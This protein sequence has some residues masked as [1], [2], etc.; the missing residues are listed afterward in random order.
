MKRLPSLLPVAALA[1]GC[2]RQGRQSAREHA[3][4]ARSPAADASARNGDWIT[5]LVNLCIRCACFALVVVA[6]SLAGTLSLSAQE[7][8][9]PVP[10]NPTSILINNVRVFDGVSDELRQGNLLIVGNKIKQ[11]TSAPITPP[12]HSDVIDGGGR[13]LMPG[14]TDAHWHMTIAAN[15][16]ANL[17][18]ADPGLMYANTV[19]EAHRTLLRGF[20]TVRDM[21]GPTFGI[22]AAI[23]A[24]VIPGPRVYPSGALISQTTGH[25][26]F[27]PPYERPKALGGRS[28]HLED[29]GE[30]VVADGVR[31]VLAAV[32]EQLKKGASQIKLAAG[33]GVIS[34]FD[35]IDSTQFTPEE[36]RAAVQA[37]SDWGTYVAVHVY[38]PKAI[39]RALD[40]GV[41]SIEHGHLADEATVRLITEKGAWL[42]MQPF[43]P[44]DE[45]L[46]PENAA[47]TKSM[48]GA[49]ER[50]LGWAK[51]YRAKVAFG[52]DLLFDPTGAYKENIMLTR[53]AKI[54][55]N[56]DVLKIA[57]SGNC[58]L[59][60]QSG[61]RN[62][63]KQPKLGVL[64]EGAWADML[65][66]DG[67]P[68]K[69]I[70]VLADPQRNFVV[71]IKDGKVYKNALR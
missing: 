14:L 71:I 64:E 34:N 33:G 20:T 44:G 17:E 4:A 35:L 22:K 41:L 63:Y 26:D 16:L 65:L 10:N 45:P 69:E 23:D 47:K 27:A 39:R 25:G 9:P 50:V 59:F 61:E 11:M 19:A 29:L 7:V 51:K 2:T 38:T 57:T 48:V 6:A 58:E 12:P 3:S 28:S 42:S 43:E 1:A 21:A 66:L 40:A 32:R 46:S 49:W 70:N 8:L 54:Y 13:V 62:P 68:T 53:L 60:A 36:L 24:G 52:T 5:V 56:V 31:E 18:Q 55:S 30:F 67:D 15:A 37:A